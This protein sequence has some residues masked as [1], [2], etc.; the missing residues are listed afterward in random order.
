MGKADWR[1]STAALARDVAR[2][3]T[4]EVGL[5]GRFGKSVREVVRGLI[6]QTDMR[7]RV[8]LSFANIYSADKT[9][10]SLWRGSPLMSSAADVG[11]VG[12]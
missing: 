4:W 8:R 5:G 9:D 6:E 2:D 3:V 11:D 7:R 12:G 10:R 1:G